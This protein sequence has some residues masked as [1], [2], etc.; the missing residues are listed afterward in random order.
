MMSEAGDIALVISD[1][2][3]GGAQR[4]LVQLAEHWHGQ[5]RRV[6][7]VT[8]SDPA[9]DFFTLP[10]GVGRITAGGLGASKNFVSRVV[11][12]VWRL[13]LLRRALKKA[14]APVIVVFVGRTILHTILAN[15]GLPSQIVASERNDPAIQRLGYPWDTLRK[16]LYRRARLVTANSEG[17][18][19][20]LRTFVPEEKLALV[21][22][23]VKLPA[24]SAE[25]N[26]EEVFLAVGRLIHK[27][28]YD[29]LLAAFAV[30]AARIPSWRL[31]I[32]GRGE[33]EA[34]LKERCIEMGI[35]D[36]VQWFGL[37]ND[38]G[39][40]YLSAGVMVMASRHE[41]MPNV[42]LEAMAHGLPV[43]V[44]DSSPGPLELVCDGENGR[45]VESENPVALAEVM[46]QLARDRD[47]RQALGAAARRDVAVFADLGVF[48]MWDEVLAS[49][50]RRP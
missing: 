3:D 13:V 31:W 10:E 28:G 40:Y 35:A 15:I 7:V 26:R 14:A 23:P 12:N 6:V 21:R 29:V 18:I 37:V 8:Q 2:G 41:G 46:E 48:H 47:L 11:R 17:A 27:K 42:L 32:V 44:T 22:N 43:I 9:D 34:S 5:G 50:E 25:A 30:F 36:R 38:P 4:V 1:M 20:Y 39:P 33:L 19:R 49:I 24:L 16:F 45:V